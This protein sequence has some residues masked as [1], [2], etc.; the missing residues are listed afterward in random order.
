[1][2]NC[3]K[4]R[5]LYHRS[6]ILRHSSSWSAGGRRGES[7]LFF[8][9]VVFLVCYINRPFFPVVWSFRCS[10]TQLVA[11][12]PLS[13]AFSSVSPGVDVLVFFF[14]SLSSWVFHGLFRLRLGSYRRPW[15][16]ANLWVVKPPQGYGNS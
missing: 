2:V 1:M 4:L 7:F 14:L 12:F 3:W 10:C 9:G 5:R 16:V 8:S 6:F 15:H 11:F 13:L